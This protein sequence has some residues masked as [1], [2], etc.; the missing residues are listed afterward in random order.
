MWVR[1]A[2]LPLNVVF[3]VLMT[4]LLTC[5]YGSVLGRGLRPGLCSESG[6]RHRTWAPG[7]QGVGVSPGLTFLVFPCFTLTPPQF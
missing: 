2:L 1:L 4:K 3:T 6:P 5:S 7:P